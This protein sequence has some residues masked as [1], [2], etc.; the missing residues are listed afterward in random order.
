MGKNRVVKRWFAVALASLVLGNAGF[1][2][3]LHTNIVKAETIIPENVTL[4]KVT[5]QWTTNIAS[6]VM[7]T[8]AELQ[9]Q[10][11][12]QQLFEMEIQPGSSFAHIEAGS[13]HGKV[14][15]ME[16]V[17]DQAKDVS[18]P[19]H[20]VVGGI[21]G[22]FYDM[23]NGIPID[24]MMHEGKVLQSPSGYG[25]VGFKPDGHAV[26]GNP[27]FTGAVEVNGQKRP[28]TAV[29]RGRG[30][31]E[32][33]LYTPEYVADTGTNDFGTEVI[34]H[35]SQ[36]T[37]TGSMAGSPAGENTGTTS[38]DTVV[39]T[40]D[41]IPPVVGNQENSNG[42][43]SA[44]VI[45]KRQDQGKAPLQE[46]M[47]VLSGH[48]IAKDFLNTI[49]P[50]DEI[51]ISTK[52]EAPWDQVKEAVGGHVMLTNGSINVNLS[53]PVNTGVH[54]R[55]AVGV[56]ADGTPFFVVIDGRQPGYSEGVTVP[57]LAQLMKDMGA[58]DAI[59]LDGGG[60]TTF[61][62]RQPGDASVTVQ[63]SPSD[64]SERSVANS[65]LVV[66]SAPEGSLSKIAIRPAHARILTGSHMNLLT[67][68]M[69]ENYNPVAIQDPIAWSTEGGIG[70]VDSVGIFTAGNAAAKGSI[71]AASSSGTGSAPVEMVD[72]L[73]S[74]SIFPSPLTVNPGQTVT[75]NAT[76]F[77]NG[78][79]VTAD[80][81]AFK[82]EVIGDIGSIDG[83]GKFTAKNETGTGSIRV[84]FG[85]IES[86][87]K[88]DVGKPPIILEDFE[89]GIGQWTKSGAA[90]NSIDISDSV[91]PDPVRFGNHA[92]KLSYDF[93]GK[94]GT[95]GAYA[96]PKTKI[97]LDGY[98]QKIGMWVYGDGK[99]HW[100]R[101]Q[102][103][104]GNN[105]TIAIDLTGSVP[106]VDWIGW[107]YV[108]ATIP[109][110]KPTPLKL[111]LAV[112]VMETSNNN[113]NSGAI[114]VDN[115]RAVYGETNEDLAGPSFTNLTPVSGGVIHNNMPNML[116]TIQDDKSGV[117]GASIKVTLDG[118][119]VVFAY[120][121]DTANITFKP[122]AVLADGQH[123]VEINAADK[124]GNPAVPSAKWSFTVDTGPDT[125][126]PSIEIISPMNGITTRT[127]EP[128]IAVKITDDYT[129]VDFIKAK[130]QVDGTEVA[131][132]LDAA[133]NM[134]Y[135]MPETKWVPG[136]EHQVKVV[137]VDKSGNPAEQ[138]WS[139]TIG[140]P[141][142]QPK[143]PNHFQMSVIGDGG[144]YTAGQLGT[145]ADVLLRE[146]INRI[147]KESSELVGYTGD[148]VE[149]DTPANYQEAINSLNA[150]KA[151][152]V[153]TI[154]NHEVSG[155][156]SRLDYERAFGEQ[157][158]AYQYGNTKIIGLDSA[159]GRITPSDASQWPWLKETLEKTAQNNIIIFMHIPPDEVSAD[160]VDFKTG[161][162]FLNAAEA[163]RFYNLLG[164]YKSG[165]PEKNIIVL[166]GD[167]HAYEYKK[168]QGVDYVITGGGGKYTHVTPEQGGFYHYLNLKVD[169][170]KMTWDA[171]PLLDTITFTNAPS[172][173]KINEQVKLN[174][175]GTF[176]TSSNIPITM[177]ITAPF[178]QEWISS[179][180][181]VATVDGTGTV[182]GKAAGDVT[183]T[184]KSGWREAQLQLNIAG[185]VP[186]PGTK[187]FSITNGLL[188]TERDMKAT[189]TI[190][191]SAAR[192]EGTEVV[193]F[194][195]MKGTVPAGLIAHEM[196]IQ[197]A[198]QVSAL[199][200][201][202]GEG[203]TV[204]VYVVDKYGNDL[205]NIGISLAEP[206]VLK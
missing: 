115:I 166:S 14:A 9:S 132:Q 37:S 176:I 13:T 171:I 170:D 181:S 72:K 69:D 70:K 44:T 74:I 146:Q 78:L 61:V 75:V 33:I 149:N 21:N 150:F 126:A 32:L 45:E 98:P 55:T 143:D 192:H 51:K 36:T 90:F 188:N 141:L 178:K 165:H 35:T 63:N 31:D 116:A 148:I 23:T 73:T 159:S 193:V 10:R 97:T 184:V 120:D 22:D 185:E 201:V 128:R 197:Q 6:G 168:V 203:Y 147:N 135:Y 82:W 123:T 50:G 118:N 144:Y 16:Q 102:L 180:P 194:Q 66:S 167:L 130:M 62:A 163:Q 131:Y 153:V 94:T 186:A 169:G 100:L 47:L 114:Y 202:K 183:I 84:S 95:S 191:P 125:K 206:A 52:L 122:S 107:K 4:G 156:G 205:D 173:I 49:K 48:G 127:D 119:P 136:S 83:N 151:P 5:D 139:F 177:P 189:V 137:A 57:E 40:G 109:A 41:T 198:K 86:T 155:T 154:G 34:L 39:T 113:K 134:L 195:L 108:E 42:T 2:D 15:G 58:V 104:D 200:N 38:G 26:I 142:G 3:L 46:G 19:G 91:A 182:T 53:D 68:G 121:P 27:G 133:S 65:L 93:T 140:N 87:V 89:N 106:G 8:K 96:L 187:P 80:S 12:R 76:G 18:R 152:Y 71:K 101:A 162:G 199:F 60:S 17:S 111:D 85:N 179:N 25:A 158:Y 145:A 103:R 64:G 24:F 204:R 160:G 30:A 175:S 196:D 99:R 67:K 77:A 110:A 88:V 7:E 43:I 164:S 112:R 29:N 124:A 79:P 172:T 1:L 28:I 138:T 105:G 117:D 92:L 54:P 81:N 190:T 11:G 56:K 161:H 129:G 20:V 174:A 59:N 157:T